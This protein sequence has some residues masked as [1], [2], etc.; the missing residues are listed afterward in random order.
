MPIA[1]QLLDKGHVDMVLDYSVLVTELGE[2]KGLANEQDVIEYTELL[3]HK[4]D[5]APETNRRS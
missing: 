3:H 5:I 4:Q 2:R 1:L